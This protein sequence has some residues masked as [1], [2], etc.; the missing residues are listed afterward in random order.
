MIRPG[1]RRRQAFLPPQRGDDCRAPGVPRPHHAVAGRP[2]G[3]R[4]RRG[5]GA[6]GAGGGEGHRPVGPPRGRHHPPRRGHQRGRAGPGRG[7][8]PRL[9]PRPPPHRAPHHAPPQRLLRGRC[10]AA[11]RQGP[12]R[13]QPRRARP[14]RLRRAQRRRVPWPQGGL[15]P[16]AHLPGTVRR[17]RRRGHRRRRRRA[18]RRAPALRDGRRV[19][20]RDPG[21]G[22]RPQHAAHGARPRRPRLHQGPH[23]SSGGQRRRAPVRRVPA[24]RPRRRRMERSLLGGAPWSPVDLGPNR[25][26]SPAGA[27]EAGGEPEGA[28]GVRQHAGQHADLRARRAAAADGGGRR[29][30]IS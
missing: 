3:H 20:G 16:D 10:R 7:P 28:K 4:R 13:E 14:R 5:A 9:A 18:P 1:I 19:A 12:R 26:R 8:P 27:R 30:S 6:R 15:P 29:R 17:R 22:A 11:P 24:A 25:E 21:N 23:T 2:A